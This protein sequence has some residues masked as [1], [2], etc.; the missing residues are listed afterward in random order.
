M[1]KRSDMAGAAHDLRVDTRRAFRD[2][3]ITALL[4]FGLFLPLIG[5]E[6]VTNVRNDLI[7]TTRWPLLFAV[8]A[9]VGLGRLAYSL[10]IVP[11]LHRPIATPDTR[12]AAWRIH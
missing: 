1:S 8:V 9:I 2:A 10:V 7:L 6:T 12:R 5:F 3:G 4:A 11:R